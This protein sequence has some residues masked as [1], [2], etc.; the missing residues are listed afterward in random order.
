MVGFSG[1]LTAFRT[2]SAPLSRIDMV[3]IR[4]LLIFGLGALIFALLPLPFAG[5]PPD[6]LWTVATVL[7]AIF[8]LVWPIQSPFWNRARGV[9]PRRPGLF[10]GILAIEALLGLALLAAAWSGVAHPGFY[11]GGVV[12]CLLVALVTFVAQVFSLLSVD[13]D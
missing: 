3:Y 5:S 6:R 4:I 12:W 8:L 2:A 1:L 13:P 11:A 9:R 10:Y 7:L